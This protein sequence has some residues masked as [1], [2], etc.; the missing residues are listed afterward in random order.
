MPQLLLVAILVLVGLCFLHTSRR[1]SRMERQSWEDLVKEL[2]P[3]KSGDIA[4]IAEAYLRPRKSQIER[5]PAELYEMLGGIAGLST[6]YS[7]VRVMLDI[8]AYATQW[9]EVEAIVVTELL[10]REAQKVKKTIRSLERR[11]L[12]KRFGVAAPFQ[13]MEIAA[14]YHL[15]TMRLLALYEVSHVGLYPRLVEAL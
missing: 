8:A 2:K 14:T 10:R 4:K 7:N 6:M 1:K 15:M 9:N 12:L 11:L 5:E 3:V 13:I